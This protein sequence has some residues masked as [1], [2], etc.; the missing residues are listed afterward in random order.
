MKLI[1][2]PNCKDIVKLTK[3]YRTCFCGQSSGKYLDMVS[4]EIHGLAIPIAFVNTELESVT[5]CRPK[6]NVYFDAFVIG[7]DAVTIKNGN[8]EILK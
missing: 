4:A 5:Q 7:E 8:K 3:I 1:Y 2:C 6:T